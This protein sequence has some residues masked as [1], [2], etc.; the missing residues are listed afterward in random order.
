MWPNLDL[1][2]FTEEILNGTSLVQK[3]GWP[4]SLFRV[5]PKG[6]FLIKFPFLGSTSFQIRD[7]PQR[8]FKVWC[9]GY[10]Y[11]ANSFSKTWTQVLRW[12][13]CCS[14]RSKNCSSSPIREKV[15][16]AISKLFLWHLYQSKTLTVSEMSCLCC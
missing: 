14:R 8:L 1:V 4:K 2:A 6:M 5:F 12:F 15:P 9:S 13:K 10:Y 16:H 3:M 11:C 7:R